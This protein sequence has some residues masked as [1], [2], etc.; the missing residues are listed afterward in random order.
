M[1][2]KVWLDKTLKA[3]VIFII[4]VLHVTGSEIF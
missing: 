2:M 4:V 1:N 3:T